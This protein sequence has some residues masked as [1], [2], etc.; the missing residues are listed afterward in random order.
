[1]KIFEN[2]SDSEL[3][4][5][6]SGGQKSAYQELFE[7]YAPRIYKFSLSYLKNKTDSEE[8]V[9][10]VF[11]KIWEKGKCLTIRKT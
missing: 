3:A 1:M 8:L 4:L 9:Q 10:E 6:I 5:R 2:I 11:L 7:R